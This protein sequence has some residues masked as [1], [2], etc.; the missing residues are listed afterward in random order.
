MKKR[1]LFSLQLRRFKGMVRTILAVSHHG[2]WQ[3]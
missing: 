3:W 1:G 2:G